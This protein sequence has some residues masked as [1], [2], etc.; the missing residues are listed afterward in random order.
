MVD[1]QKQFDLALF[2]LLQ[3]CA[4]DVELV[5]F[6][7]RFTGSLSLR[8][9][10]RVRHGA[11]D[12]QR[13]HLAEQRVDDFDF[14]RDLCPANDGDERTVRLCHGFAQIVE[15]FL[16]QEPCCTLS[17]VSFDEVSNAFGGSVGSMR[18][19]ECVVDVDFA[20]RCK[21]F[22]KCGI[23]LFFFSMETKVFEQQGL[24][25]FQVAREF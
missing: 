9:E 15:F 16:H 2:G 13:I 22:C 25:G 3:R 7:E 24:P 14:V 4:R 19:T 8:V 20:E 1:G 21:L 18:G 6:D 12:E 23:V 5:H 17:A 10:E 11:A